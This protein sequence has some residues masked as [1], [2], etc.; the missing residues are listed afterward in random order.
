[1]M[2]DRARHGRARPV[3]LLAAGL[4]ALLLVAPG[5]GSGVRSPAETGGQP[6]PANV[7]GLEAKPGNRSVSLVWEQVEAPDVVEYVVTRSKAS[8][9]EREPA[10]VV[11]R[12]LGT[13][14]TD[15]AVRNGVR[16]RYRVF[17]LDVLGNTSAG[18][19]AVV[20]PKAPLLA[21]PKDGELVGAP[22]EFAWVPA[23]GATYY[24][25]QVFRLA[26]TGAG[27]GA[28]A[29][30]ILSAWPLRARFALESSWTYGDRTQELEP[31]RYAWYV[32]PGRGKRAAARYGK[33]LG[34]SVFVVEPSGVESP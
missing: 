14:F 24:N 17:A 29:V 20:V 1:M 12:G 33:L 30:K 18:V 27:D 16:Y 15:R 32:W 2:R 5:G 22:V 11:Y 34:Y 21:R 4:A 31:G 19:V 25:I 13:E 9:G 3:A 6:V 23:K 10:V 7:R 26:G 8:V 28:E